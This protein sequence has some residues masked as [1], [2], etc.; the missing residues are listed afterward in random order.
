MLPADLFAPQTIAVPAA[1]ERLRFVLPWPPSVN[2]Y[3]RAMAPAKGRVIVFPTSEAKAYRENVRAIVLGQIG[4]PKP[5]TCE[6]LCDMVLHMPDR[7]QR[8]ADNYT[9][10]VWDALQHAG[11]FVN[12]QQIHSFRVTKAPLITGG[13]VV[14]DLWER[15]AC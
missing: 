9:K 13:A 12:D 2:T 1:S 3:W 15:A 4:I 11:V 6:L 10:C 5:F 8:D 14:I 7:R